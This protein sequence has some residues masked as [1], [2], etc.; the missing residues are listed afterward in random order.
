MIVLKQSA[1]I[2]ENTWYD[3]CFCIYAK[4]NK[5]SKKTLIVCKEQEKSGKE[6]IEM[7]RVIVACGSG[8]A[9]SQ[10]V[11]MKVRKILKEEGIKAEVLAIRV[12]DLKDYISNSDVYV[13]IVNTEETYEI[14]TVDGIAFLAGKKEKE[15]EERKKLIQLLRME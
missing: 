14:A 3:G 12:H 11:A 7:K 10:M 6:R 15:E 4:D 8:I 9:V 1:Y 2:R 13:K 5:P